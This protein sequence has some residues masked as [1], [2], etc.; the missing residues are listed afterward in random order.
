[1]ANK[2]REVESRLLVL[3]S[4][5]FVSEEEN[6]EKV[7]LKNQ[8]FEVKNKMADLIRKHPAIAA[9]PNPREHVRLQSD[10]D[11]GGRRDR[12]GRRR[13]GVGF[14]STQRTRLTGVHGT[15]ETC[16]GRRGVRTAVRK[17]TRRCSSAS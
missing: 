14:M 9:F 7:S 17:T 10:L 1:M 15:G 13:Q 3:S 16:S 5:S 4:R 8:K 6:L 11:V 12:I 2:H